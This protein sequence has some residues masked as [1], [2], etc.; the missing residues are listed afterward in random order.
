MRLEVLRE[1]DAEVG[2]REVGDGDAGREVLQVDHRVLELE[3][4]L[5]AVLQ[6]VHLV[7][8]LLLDQVLLAGGRDVEQHHAAAHPLL[9]V[10][11]LLQLHVGPEVDELDALVGRADAVDAA[12]ALDDAHRVP[13]D[14]V[15]D[16][17]VAVLEVL[18][19]GDAVGGDE[20]VELALAGKLLRALLR[21]R[22]ER[23]EDRGEILAQPGQRRLVAARA[24][25]QRG[26]DAERRLR[27]RGEL[28][29]EVAAVSAKAVK[30]ITLRLP[31]LIGLRH[32]LF[33]HLAQRRELGVAGGIDLRRRREQRRQSVAILDQVLLP[34]D[35]DPRPSAAP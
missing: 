34:A 33:D 21:A 9:E 31:G 8:G 12:E 28:V 17:P 30:T 5:A 35:R 3:Q 23:G 19:L 25:D 27:P 26:V 11:V 1:V 4:L 22:C 18:A 14:V 7:A 29:V 15:V 10:D 13:V 16:E 20:Q 2:E 32:L 6:I 24:G